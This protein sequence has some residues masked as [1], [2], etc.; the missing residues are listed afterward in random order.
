MQSADATLKGGQVYPPLSEIRNSLRIKWYRCPIATPRLRELLKRSDRKGLQ[1]A[2]GHFGLWLLSGAGVFLC[3][4][5]G[6]WWGLLPALWIHG[7]FACFFNGTSVHE[8][9]HGTVFKT[10]WLNR[11]FLYTFSTI[12]WWDPFDYAS[13]H[14]FHHRYTLHPEGDRENLLPL[15]PLVGKT[16]LIQKLTF[17]LYSPPGRNFGKGGF[18]N[19]VI[20][21]ALGALGKTGDQR[22]PSNEWLR[23]LHDDLPNEH[24]KSVWWSRWLIAFH[25]SVA[26]F[27]FLTGQ[28]IWILIV[29][30]SSYFS[31][32]CSYLLGMTQHCGLKEND[33]DFRKSVRSIRINRISE[34]LYWHMNWHTEHHM[35][36][37]VPCYNLKALH[38]EIKHDMPVPR[39]LF[40]AWREM[41]ETWNKQKT[42]SDYFYDTPVPDSTHHMI[43]H[44]ESIADEDLQ[45]SIGE[46]APAELDKN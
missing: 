14:T 13:S 24:R 19:A 7:A 45:S 39:T 16:F 10:P 18:V 17:N 15:S 33:S 35:F 27:S 44:N 46:L 8:L 38:Q 20:S 25:L 12:S 6:Q 28:W 3:F 43:D 21:T 1:Q 4:A 2:G 23:A 37:G 9:G 31:T 40:Q 41:I 36:A 34:F 42:D 29:T 26:L 30:C 11:L 5:N 32:I 22:V